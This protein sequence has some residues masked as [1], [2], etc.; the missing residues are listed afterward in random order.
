MRIIGQNLFYFLFLRLEMVAFAE[1]TLQGEV[2]SDT[3]GMESVGSW[4]EK[5]FRFVCILSR[6]MG[7][8]TDARRLKIS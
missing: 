3:G 8:R 7:A 2:L 1:R 4:E 5:K 6:E